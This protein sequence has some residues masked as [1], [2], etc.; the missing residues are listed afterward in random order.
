MGGQ[1]MGVG[2]GKKERRKR[3]RERREK[4]GREERG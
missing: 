4:E 2:E 3:G 1:D